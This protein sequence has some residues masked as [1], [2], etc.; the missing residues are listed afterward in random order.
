MIQN[1]WLRL[2]LGTM[3][4]LVGLIWAAVAYGSPELL[5]LFGI[6]I[7]GLVAAMVIALGAAVRRT[8]QRW[9]AAVALICAAPMA[10]IVLRR[11]VIRAVLEL[12][13]I[14]AFVVVGSVLTVIAALIILVAKPPPEAADRV[15]RAVAQPRSSE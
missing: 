8:P 1:R 3:C 4:S 7:A 11:G 9:P 6:Q 12:D 10:Q 14:S 2:A 13:R 15:A 5:W